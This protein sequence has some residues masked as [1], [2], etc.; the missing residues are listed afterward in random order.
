[1]LRDLCWLNNWGRV[2]IS[3]SGSLLKRSLWDEAMY[4]PARLD[5]IGGSICQPP[6]FQDRGEP[7]LMGGSEWLDT[8]TAL[9]DLTEEQQH[10]LK[11]VQG[12]AC[13]R[14]KDESEQVRAVWSATRVC[15]ESKLLQKAKGITEVAAD[16][17]ARRTVE[18]SLAGTLQGDYM[19][20]LPEGRYVSVK[21]VLDNWQ[22]WDKRKTLDPLEPDHRGGESCGI[23]YLT[24]STPTLFSFAHGGMTYQLARQPMKVVMQRGRQSA[25]ADELAQAL[26]S[27]GDIFTS[28]GGELVQARNGRFDVLDKASAQYL[29]GHRVHAVIN[30]EGRE[31]PQNISNELV[32]MTLAAIGQKPSQTPPTLESVTSLPYA[33]ADGYEVLSSGYSARTSVYNTMQRVDTP[34]IPERPT[35]SDV[36]EALKTLWEPWS[37]YIWASPADRGGMLSA[38][39]TTVL[40]PVMQTAPGFFLDAPV[41]GSGKTKAALALGALMTGELA[42]ITPFVASRNQEEEYSKSIISLLRSERRFWLIDNVTGRFESAALAGLVT[43]GKVQGRILGLSKEGSFSGRLMLCATGNNATLGSDL[44]RRFVCCRIDT[45]VERPTEVSH[46]FEP[47]QAALANRMKIAVAVLTVLRAYR[48]GPPVAIRGG[49]DFSEWAK[50]VREPIVWLQQQGYT[51]AAGIG[52]VVDPAKALGGGDAASDPAREGLAQ[53]LSGLSTYLKLPKQFVPADVHK[54][55]LAGESRPQSPEGLIREG[56]E[57]LSNGKPVSG[58][59]IGFTL[60]NSHER[61]TDGLRLAKAGKNK[62]GTRWQVLSD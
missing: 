10:A 34:E 9:P 47:E 4:Q 12:A 42:G 58:R 37:S 61:R 16:A 57:T 18:S 55:Y 19:I 60:S 7:V 26:C 22:Q 40:R 56:L 38:I 1:M 17:Q 62:H 43:S 25:T 33:T 50:L 2:E 49:S 54:A 46:R 36:V 13:A 48:Q 45:G 59:T 21:D 31:A 39:F 15:A 20:P 8:R 23:L 53:L 27:H 28:G 30:R 11:L 35:A 32:V 3:T 52:E 51:V 41:Q 5:F 14:L 6:L 44:H 29:L 24:G